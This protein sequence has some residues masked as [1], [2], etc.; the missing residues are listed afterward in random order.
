MGVHNN[1]LLLFSTKWVSTTTFCCYLVVNGVTVEQSRISEQLQKLK[2][3]R[4][5][6]RSSYKKNRE[7]D[8]QM[9]HLVKQLS[10]LA[11]ITEP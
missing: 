3:K 2:V 4:P 7:T 11:D 8:N 9:L 10:L 1:I 5:N 6:T